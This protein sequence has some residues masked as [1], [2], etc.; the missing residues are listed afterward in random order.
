MLNSEQ[1][2]LTLFIDLFGIFL[3]M[4]CSARRRRTAHGSLLENGDISKTEAHTNL[5]NGYICNNCSFHADG[6]EDET[7][8]SL[9]CS[10]SVSSAYQ[11]AADATMT[12]SLNIVDKTGEEMIMSSRKH[13]LS[14]FQNTS[15]KE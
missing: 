13:R 11:T 2:T 14:I 12:T 15:L 1:W 9:P 8:Y 7:A 4:L 6:K 3:L 5:A 10:T